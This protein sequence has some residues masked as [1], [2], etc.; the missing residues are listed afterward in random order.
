MPVHPCARYSG[1]LTMAARGNCQTR[2]YF[3]SVLLIPSA[4]FSLIRDTDNPSHQ[5]PDHHSSACASRMNQARNDSPVLGDKPRLRHGE[6]PY[7]VPNNVQKI[8]NCWQTPP[9]FTLETHSLSRG[10]VLHAACAGSD[11][12][13]FL[14]I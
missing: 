10:D 13:V 12:N 5:T 3:T 2:P 4:L 8:P 7:P 6:A 9:G 14:F 11:K 1:S